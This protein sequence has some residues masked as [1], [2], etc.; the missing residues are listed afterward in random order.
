MAAVYPTSLKSFTTKQNKVDLV[1]AAHIND[2]QS[3]VV[4]LQTYVGTNPHGSMPNVAARLNSMLNPSGYLISSA[5]VPQPTAPGFLW[6]DTTAGVLKFIKTDSTTQSVGGSL[7][8][9]IFCDD[10]AMLH[11]TTFQ[12]YTTYGLVNVVY[13][14][15]PSSIAP[16]D[17]YQMKYYYLSG[18]TGFSQIRPLIY[19]YKIS[20]I[21]T[22]KCITSL[23]SSEGKWAKFSVGVSSTTTASGSHTGTKPEAETLSLDISGLA[24]GTIYS[25]TFKGQCEDG[26]SSAFLGHTTIW[27]E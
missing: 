13:G 10:S 17:P 24:N 11:A 23:W 9:L 1:D 27:G 3:E 15:T 22:L 16:T 5:G 20:G 25:I 14:T 26:A 18:S 2:L 19:F 7:S 6:Y 8:N 12:T 4:A 21:N